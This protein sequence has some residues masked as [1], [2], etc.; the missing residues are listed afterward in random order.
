[1][2]HAEFRL[3][4]KS[5]LCFSNIDEKILIKVNNKASDLHPEALLL[6]SFY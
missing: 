1:M 5:I 4:R 6:N 2:L 3:P